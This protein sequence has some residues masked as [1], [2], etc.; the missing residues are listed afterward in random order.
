MDKLCKLLDR[1]DTRAF[2]A[3]ALTS[4]M[5]G[6]TFV[7]ALRAPE[8]DAFKVLLGAMLTVGFASA[9]G[10]Y[11]N[12]SSSS[13]KKDAAIVSMATSP[14]S[15]PGSPPAAPV[16]TT[17]TVTNNATVTKTEPAATAG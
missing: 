4:S 13:D 14:S 3:I 11:F 10:W 8:S 2:I 5:I 17:T 15:A 12:S 6:L 7:L 9:V 1:F 16:S